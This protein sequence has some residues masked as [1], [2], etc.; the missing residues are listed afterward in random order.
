MS[1]I[2]EVMQKLIKDFQNPFLEQMF[3]QI[4]HGKMLRSS[5]VLAIAGKNQQSIELCAIIELIQLASLLHDDV[6]DESMIRRGQKSINASYGSKSAVMLGD[7]LYAKAFYHLTFFD[8]L[9]AQSLSNAV[10]RLSSGE[11][12]DVFLAQ[13]FNPSKEKY[14]LMIEEKTASLI[15]SS[16]ECAAILAGLDAKDYFHYGKCLGIAF[17]IIDDILDITQ[18]QEV[19][20]K[21]A[22]NDFKE[23]KTTL[24]YLFLFEAL[25][26]EG[27][28]RLQGLCGKELNQDE[29]KWIKDHL[30][31]YSCI[32]KSQQLA[33]GIAKD[34]LVKIKNPYNPALKEMIDAM[35]QR[36]F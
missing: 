34:S 22:M 17:Q 4:S 21:P 33:I 15:A 11:I 36:S 10:C 8:S 30:E 19:L 12:Y 5:M 18:P 25:D 1:E 28:E 32:E 3:S 20:G 6:I 26:H 27:R 7:A 16:A 35:I 9:I 2:I 23:G 31:K 14:C 29:K 24:P 13:S